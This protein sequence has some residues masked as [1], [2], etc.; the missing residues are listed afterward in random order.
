MTNEVKIQVFRG[1]PPSIIAGIK[2]SVNI[3]INASNA[4]A[5]SASSALTSETNASNSENVAIEEANNA[6]NSAIMAKETLDTAETTITAAKNVALG[7]VTESI[8]PA[9]IAASEAANTAAQVAAISNA[10]TF[11]TKTLMDANLNYIDG[12]LGLVVNDSFLDNNGYYVKTGVSG[13]GSW[14]KISYDPFLLAT[15]EVRELRTLSMKTN[16]KTKK[17]IV[18]FIDDDGYSTVYT[19]LR[20][21]AIEKSFKFNFCVYVEP[22][23]QKQSYMLT[24]A[25]MLTLQSEGHEVLSHGYVKD[26]MITNVPSALL[27]R[28]FG[29]SKSYLRSLGLDVNSYVWQGGDYNQNAL[30]IVPK[31][32]DSA[33]AIDTGSGINKSNNRSFDGYKAHRFGFDSATLAD[34]KIQV[35]NLVLYGGWLT[36]MTHCWMATWTTPEKKQD[37]RD[38][39]DYIK[40]KNIDIV[41]VREGLDIHGN[42]LDYGPGGA[43]NTTNSFRIDKQGMMLNTYNRFFSEPGNTVFATTPPSFFQENTLNITYHNSATTATDFPGSQLGTLITQKGVSGLVIQEWYPYS[44][45]SGSKLQFFYKRQRNNIPGTDGWNAWEKVTFWAQI[46][47][48]INGADPNLAT[49]PLGGPGQITR[50]GIKSNGYYGEGYFA[51]NTNRKFKRQMK[52]DGSMTAWEE[53]CYKKGVQYNNVSLPAIDTLKMATITIDISA[54]GIVN[55]DHALSLN[56]RAALPVGLMYSFMHNGTT[57]TITLFNASA[58][59]ITASTNHVT[60]VAVKYN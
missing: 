4:A 30:N 39:I 34:A 32:Y 31:Y 41:T 1:M 18:S 47:E 46:Q 10:V 49:Y 59:N 50:S 20:E 42:I 13:A 25:Q 43:G 23:V 45:G 15:R 12:R 26:I 57:L 48:E 33:W 60:V 27:E 40:S 3:T 11:T 58:T 5:N 2:D 14:V 9:Q 24:A 8:I 21:L 16:N 38:L 51:Y 19:I 37:L 6:A 22:L 28:E 44:V 56:W 55:N 7:E 53:I 36:F 54:V 35:D 29:T 17:N 52:S